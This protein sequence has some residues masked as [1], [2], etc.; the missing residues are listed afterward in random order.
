MSREVV[1]EARGLKKY[2]PITAGILGRIVGWVRAVDGVD[3][4]VRGGETHAIV[5]ESGCGKS[6]LARTLIGLYEPTAGKIFFR[7]VELTSLSPKDRK[8]YL[9]KMS[10]VFQDPT[11][12]L[13]PR[14]KVIEIITSP[15]EYNKV[16]SR[17][18]RIRRARELIELV[19]LDASFLNRYPHELSGGQRQRVAIARALA[20]DPELVILDEPTSALDV[21]VQAKILE[22]LK[23]LQSRLGLTYM[24]ITHNLGIVRYF[25]HHVS[26]M[27]AGKIVESA[28]IDT[29]FS[30]P[31][32]P[33]TRALIAAIPAITPEEEE[34]KARLGMRAL[35]GEPPSL[36]DPPRGCRFH[37]RC[38]VAR[39]ICRKK[40]PPLKN[41]GDT[42]V[43]CWLYEGGGEGS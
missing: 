6:T 9:R 27:Y 19:E 2:F 13:N 24:L 29:L 34:L 40:R 7:G 31:H 21:S 11:S 42:M 41:L 28:P 1:L 16:G 17:S 8:K 18:E 30:K 35:P 25:A 39:E 36:A 5:G 23:R 15:L 37:P 33:Y 10:I 3:L 14:R 12:S 20:L 38:P 22:L 43:A 26:V 32:H 4:E